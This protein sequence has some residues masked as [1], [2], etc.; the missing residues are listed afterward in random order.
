MNGTKKVQF[1][2]HLCASIAMCV[3]RFM[4]QIHSEDMPEDFD[5]RQDFGGENLRFVVSVQAYPIATDLPTCYAEDEQSNE[6]LSQAHSY[7]AIAAV[8]GE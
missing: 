6:N 7:S 1:A 8:G 2:A 5:Y 4:G 3:S